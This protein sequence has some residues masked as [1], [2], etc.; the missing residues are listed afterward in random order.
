MRFV[1]YEGNDILFTC[2]YCGAELRISNEAPLSPLGW[3]RCSCNEHYYTRCDGQVHHGR[4]VIQVPWLVK[5][6]DDS[7]E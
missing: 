7:Q 6:V 3:L 4:P 1:T 5:Q 2:G